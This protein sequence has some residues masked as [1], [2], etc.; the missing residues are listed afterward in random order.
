MKVKGMSTATYRGWAA[1]VVWR[2]A[3]CDCSHPARECQGTTLTTVPAVGDTE[4][5]VT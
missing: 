2:C 1:A 4:K 3:G 5:L